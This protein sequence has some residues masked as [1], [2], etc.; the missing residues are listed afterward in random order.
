MTATDLEKT[1][2]NG[3]RRD[4]ERGAL[5]VV[6][7]AATRWEAEPLARRWGLRSADGRIYE[8]NWRGK[9]ILLL[10]T[11]MGEE[12]TA[13]ALRLL[14]TP[15]RQALPGLACVV[16]FCGAL[17][18][19]MSSGDLVCDL[20][21]L[22]AELPLAAR[23]IAARLGLAVHFGRIAHST[24]VLA[25]PAEKEERGRAERASAVDMETAAVRGWAQRQGLDCLAVRVVLDAL[26]DH[27]PA[28]APAGEEA[29]EL[30]RYALRHAA[31]LPSLIRLGLKQRQGMR[32]LAAFLDLFLEAL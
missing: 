19:G 29:G 31:N 20:Q 22:D 9:N 26:H 5:R 7:C 2:N 30:L 21:G 1:K 3:L 12:N 6:L 10:K 17:Q 28:H 4:S 13:K 32:R 27:L 11:G 18:P 15:A 25:T 14:E 23:E 24:R 8:G 16:G